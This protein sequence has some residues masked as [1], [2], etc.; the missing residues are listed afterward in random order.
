MPTNDDLLPMIYAATA[1]EINNT[2][3]S[4]FLGGPNVYVTLSRVNYAL[5]TNPASEGIRRRA[6]AEQLQW[7]R[8]DQATVVKTLR[9]LADDPE[10]L[11]LLRDSDAETRTAEA[12]RVLREALGDG[13]GRETLGQ[14]AQSAANRIRRLEREV[15]RLRDAIQRPA[16]SPE[17][18]EEATDDR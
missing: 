7:W 15:A 10:Q 4:Q 6:K 11:D 1:N 12:C 2:T 14:M 13:N 3:Y 5:F 9:D 18:A 16:R 8:A 17:D